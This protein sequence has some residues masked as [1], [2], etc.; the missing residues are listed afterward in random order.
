MD[1]DLGEFLSLTGTR[2]V[3][4]GGCFQINQF[5]ISKYLLNDW[6]ASSRL[7]AFQIARGRLVFIM[8]TDVSVSVVP[9]RLTEIDSC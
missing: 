7:R 3:S 6:P 4:Q 5:D 2:A 1:L 9:G 8:D